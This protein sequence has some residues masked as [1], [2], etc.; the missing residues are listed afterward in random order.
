MVTFLNCNNDW[1][2]DR[3]KQKHWNAAYLTQQFNRLPLHTT[4]YEQIRN[5][6]KRS[7][8]S[9]VTNKEPALALMVHSTPKASGV[10]R[11]RW[12]PIGILDFISALQMGFVYF[13]IIALDNDLTCST[14]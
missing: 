14:P 10:L 8:E 13:A 4:R 3:E 9:T 12:F 2:P 1:H 7:H 5:Q 11:L 6:E